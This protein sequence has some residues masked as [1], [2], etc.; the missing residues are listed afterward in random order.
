MSVV[1][2]AR[3]VANGCDCVGGCPACVGPD[4]GTGE[5]SKEGALRLLR[6]AA[7]SAKLTV[8]DPDSSEDIVEAISDDGVAD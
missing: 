4:A 2:L 3:P 1:Q 7:E 5:N 8:Y 6:F